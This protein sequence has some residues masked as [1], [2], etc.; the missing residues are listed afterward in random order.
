MDKSEAKSTKL[1]TE[2][3]TGPSNPQK[4]INE[5]DQSQNSVKSPPKQSS[6][7]K[8]F[9]KSPK[10]S[11][12][13][14]P[15]HAGDNVK[16]MPQDLDNIS[17]IINSGRKTEEHKYPDQSKDNDKSSKAT[18][19][20]PSRHSLNDDAETRSQV[21]TLT[22]RSK[23]SKVSGRS[24][25]SREKS[26]SSKVTDV[27]KRPG[28]LTFEKIKAFV[29]EV[30]TTL[31]NIP[32]NKGLDHSIIEHQQDTDVQLEYN[33]IE[34]NLGKITQNLFVSKPIL[35]YFNDT[36]TIPSQDWDTYIR[37]LTVREL[38]VKPIEDLE[39]AQFEEL[40][41][42]PDKTDVTPVLLANF[43]QNMPDE[44]NEIGIGEGNIQKEDEDKEIYNMINNKLSESTFNLQKQNFLKDLCLKYRTGWGLR[45]S[46]VQ[47]SNLTPIEVELKPDSS[48]LRS[49][50][51]HQTKEEERFLQL[52]FEALRKVGIV[53]PAKDPIWG[54]PVFVV[55]KKISK[56]KNWVSMSNK[57]RE[58]WK[59]GNLLNHYRMVANMIK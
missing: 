4:D 57:E 5:E 55:T 18:T 43:Q 10:K 54:H 56:T 25:V 58:D 41:K 6:A 22:R 48:I 16:Y 13:E 1:P 35:Q 21:A 37:T 39:T 40:N 31:P 44:F 17:K 50:G 46:N 3:F 52:K 33:D 9:S 42:D 15:R 27:Y 12:R 8:S 45:Q 59:E 47:M 53:S 20:D 51:Y 14:S 32:M 49:D 26:Y 30:E 19:V 34:E 36:P 23:A 28:T 38:R 2:E 24:E 29:R 7:S 11:P